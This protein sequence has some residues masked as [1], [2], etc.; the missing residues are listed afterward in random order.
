MQGKVRLP[1]KFLKM[2]KYTGS[3]LTSAMYVADRHR[4]QCNK[5]YYSSVDGCCIT[6]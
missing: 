1:Y 3:I 6:P 4:I 2:E 5:F